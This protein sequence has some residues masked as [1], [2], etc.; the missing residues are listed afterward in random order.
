MNRL[1][2]RTTQQRSLGAVFK[3]DVAFSR[4]S[5]GSVDFPFGHTLA[6]LRFLWVRRKV[7]FVFLPFFSFNTEADRLVFTLPRATPTEKL[8]GALQGELSS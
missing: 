5:S 2:A 8:T 7:I 1:D 4:V 3:K 6:F